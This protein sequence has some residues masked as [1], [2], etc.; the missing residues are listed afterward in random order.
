MTDEPNGVYL[1]CHNCQHVS[2]AI[3]SKCN[4]CG[5]LDL[6]HFADA[7]GGGHGVFCNGCN[8]GYSGTATCPKCGAENAYIPKLMTIKNGGECFIATTVYGDHHHPQVQRLRSFR[9]E[10]LLNYWT[11]RRFTE[12]YYKIGPHLARWIAPH[13]R[14]KRFVRALLDKF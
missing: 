4:S 10:R 5:D 7:A 13:P 3:E 11:G 6:W 8:Q 14:V 2:L 12:A 1:T 9:D